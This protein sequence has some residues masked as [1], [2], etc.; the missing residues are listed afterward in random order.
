MGEA[1]A[2]AGV[3]GRPDLLDPDQQGVAVAVGG[4]GADV[5]DVA[6]GVALAPVLA[7]GTAPEPGAAA[8]QG[9]PDGLG[10]HPGDHQDGPVLVVLDD[11]RDQAGRVEAETGHGVVDVAG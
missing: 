9:A 11:R 3:A 8:G 6:G 5:L 10:V 1:G 7:A 2:G 4:D